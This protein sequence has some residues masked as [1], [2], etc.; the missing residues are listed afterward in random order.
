[1]IESGVG[2]DLFEHGALI[3]RIL[4]ELRPRRVACICPG[5][6]FQ[7][8]LSEFSAALGFELVSDPAAAQLVISGA[9]DYASVRALLA[10]ISD[11]AATVLAGGT[12]W[13]CGRRDARG[14]ID[15]LTESER[16]RYAF[17]MPVPAQ[18]Q[19]GDAP[20][21]VAFATVEGGPGN[22]VRTAIEDACR[23]SGDAWNV[24]LIQG[25]GGIAIMLP[26]PV[27]TAERWT[28][29]LAA[30][31]DDSTLMRLEFANAQLRLDRERLLHELER[32]LA[33]GHD[34]ET[35]ALAAQQ[36]VAAIEQR[37]GL[38]VADV[39]GLAGE[40][41]T[42]ET[43]GFEQRLATVAFEVD[44]RLTRERARAGARERALAAEQASRAELSQ[45]LSDER[46]ANA[47][48]GEVVAALGRDLQQLTDE[49]E[50]RSR[51]GSEE[52]ERLVAAYREERAFVLL[53]ANRIA[54]SGAWRWGHRFAIFRSRLL[55]RPTRGTDAVTRLLERLTKAPPGGS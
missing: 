19:L 17:R 10:G 22:G 28:R 34:L 49:L 16:D 25:F 37:L 51:A 36:S 27:A 20:S 39:A 32:A 47:R 35:R 2:V 12:A 50:R 21:P 23:D 40:L 45:W 11:P 3:L 31:G 26:A 5:T 42:R 9:G 46:G 52:L 33:S 55:R 14:A 41:A 4:T 15:D 48:W 1:V 8:R 18:V 6:R 43:P 7:A 53:Q 13:P 29:I 30:D 38:A 44:Q 54:Q 24:R